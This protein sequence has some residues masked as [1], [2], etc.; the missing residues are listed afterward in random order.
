VE[1]AAPLKRDPIFASDFQKM[2]NR[3]TGDDKSPDSMEL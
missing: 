2:V 1:F 3:I